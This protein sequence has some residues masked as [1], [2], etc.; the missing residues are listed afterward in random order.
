MIMKYSIQKETAYKG[1]TFYHFF[2]KSDKGFTL[3]ETLVAISVL[4][5]SLSG[6]LSIASSALKS[7]YYARDQVAASYLAQEGVEFVRAI[8]DQN[9][10]MSPQQSWLIGLT[11][12]IGVN[13][14][15]TVD[16][17]NFTPAA[18]C[19]GACSPLLISTAGLYNQAAGSVSRFTRTLSITTISSTEINLKV[20]VSWVSNNST[21]S[22]V[23]SENLF[24][25][26]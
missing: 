16:F 12:C 20:T 17:V 24:Q 5:L 7:A 14:Q 25:W 8:R 10:I 26:I 6:P 2:R 13:A 21:N 3:I 15:C 22:I 9:R 11:Q 18:L 1:G 4:V 23:A 19:S